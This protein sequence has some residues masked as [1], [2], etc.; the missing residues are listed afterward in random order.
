M[1]LLWLRVAAVLYAL[2]GFTVFPAVLYGV[3]RWRKSCIHL[4]GMALFFHFVSLTEMLIQGRQWMPVGV[5]EIESLLGFVVA[6]LFFLVWW[7]YD[8]ISLGVFALPATFFIVFVPALGVDRYMFPSNGVRISW[9]VAHIIALLLAYAALSFS[10]LS[11]MLYLVQERRIKRKMYPGVESWLAP[12]DTLERMALATLEFGFPC[13]TIGLLIGVVLAQETPLGAAYF[14]DPKVIASFVSWAVYV[15]LLYVRRSAGLRGRK[16][17]YVSGAVLVVMMLVWAANLL[18]H[19]H[20]F[21]V[22]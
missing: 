19:V 13:M 18:S 20:R 10:L 12:L 8:A 11:S 3:A 15:L 5:R 6:G 2:A 9:L 16:A 14:V 1:Y 22:Q 21:G 17:A 4:G 7:L